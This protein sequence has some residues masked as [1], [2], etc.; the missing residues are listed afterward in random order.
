MA[1]HDRTHHAARA[2]V[3]FTF[4]LTPHSPRAHTPS[5]RIH[6]RTHAHTHTR[7]HAHTQ[8][9]HVVAKLHTVLGVTCWRSGKARRQFIQLSSDGDE[10]RWGTRHKSHLR[11]H[12]SMIRVEDVVSIEAGI[13]GTNFDP[14]RARAGCSFSII[15]GRGTDGARLDLEVGSNQERDTYV[16][17]LE[18]LVRRR[19]RMCV[20]V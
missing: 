3:P 13:V 14:K 17:W 18:H 19:G 12:K 10:I 20:C 16:A 8:V 5:P 7:T 1:Y 6:T 15:T 4:H 11:K 9:A 2:L